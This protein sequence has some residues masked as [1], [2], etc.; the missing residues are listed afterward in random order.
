M[1]CVTGPSQDRHAEVVRA[2]FLTEGSLRAATRRSPSHVIQILVAIKTLNDFTKMAESA[3]AG[4]GFILTAEIARARAAV[5][6]I[7]IPG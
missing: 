6:R 4:K 5:H 2:P 7:R 1:V 3:L